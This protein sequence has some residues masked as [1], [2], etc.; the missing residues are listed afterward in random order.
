MKS[1][2]LV[3]TVAAIAAGLAMPTVASASDDDVVTCNARTLRGVY[4]FTASGFNIVNG[5]ALPKAIIETLVFDGRGGVLTPEVSISVNGNI[6]QP[7]QGN[8][9]VYTVDADCTGTITFG[10]GIMFDLQIKPYGKAVNMLQTNPGTVMQGTAER[11]L[12]LSAW[13]G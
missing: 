3:S 4:Q 7:P 12:A 10:D 2:L 8:P 9:G 6:I 5:V 11:T 13:G 1:I